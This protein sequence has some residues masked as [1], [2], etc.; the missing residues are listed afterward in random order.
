[1]KTA[2]FAAVAVASLAGCSIHPRQ[3]LATI[4]AAGVHPETVAHLSKNTPLTPS[5][6]I[7]LK[8]RGIP[9]SVA[10]RHLDSIGIDYEVRKEDM[11]R[12]RAA[13]VPERVREALMR[14]SDRYVYWR[15]VPRAI[16][17]DPFPW[18]EPVGFGF[19]YTY[20]RHHH[21]RHCR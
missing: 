3:Q 10:I 12:L 4:R 17:V 13:N 14:A 9:E 16:Y 11:E 2:L 20:V 19:G 1:M 6:L 18:Y 7:D 15:S 21:V 5:D 8:K